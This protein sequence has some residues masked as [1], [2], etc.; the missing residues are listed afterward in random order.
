M[1]YDDE[2]NLF[3]AGGQGCPVHGDDHLRECTMCGTEFCAACGS[4]SHLCPEC[5][6][7]SADEDEDEPDFEDVD[8]LDSLLGGDDAEVEKIIAEGE[9]LELDDE[10]FDEDDED[11]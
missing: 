7:N 5:L 11:R 9:D 8:N 1:S 2:S 6:E 4:N 3:A 10:A